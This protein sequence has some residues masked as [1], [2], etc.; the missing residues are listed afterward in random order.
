MGVRGLTN[1]LL[2]RG[3]IGKPNQKDEPDVSGDGPARP[4][5]HVLDGGRTG[6][7]TA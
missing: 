6:S 1:P 7:G 4:L 3:E 2:K 5:P